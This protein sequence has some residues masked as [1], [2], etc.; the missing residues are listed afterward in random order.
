MLSPVSCHSIEPRHHR[1]KK[2]SAFASTMI[3]LGVERSHPMKLVWDASRFSCR[4]IGPRRHHPTRPLA[5][6]SMMLELVVKCHPPTKDVADASAIVGYRHPLNQ[7]A[8][9]STM[10][11]RDTAERRRPMTN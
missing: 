5:F 4:S 6:V 3:A 2:S 10:V 8:L 1:Q 9:V 11:E 7:L